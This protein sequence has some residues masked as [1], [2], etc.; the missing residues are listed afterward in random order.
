[1]NSNLDER[2][3][4]ISQMSAYTQLVSF[5][6]KLRSG[7]VDGHG[8]PVT[9]TGALATLDSHLKT[10]YVDA[11]ENFREAKL[12]VSISILII[13]SYYHVHHSIKCDICNINLESSQGHHASHGSVRVI[14]ER[15]F[16]TV[17]ADATHRIL[18]RP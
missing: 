18:I 10:T 8:I 15:R 14:S 11:D 2:S 17:F 16:E 6:V 3:D 9:W 7:E 13:E 12:S 1:M 5:L 4:A